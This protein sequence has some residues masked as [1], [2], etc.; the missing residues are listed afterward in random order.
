MTGEP[1]WIP[2][3]LDPTRPSPAR[4]YD[5]ALGGG[6]N[7]A[8]DRAVFEQVVKIQPNTRQMAWNNRAFMRRAVIFMVESGIRQF[9]DLGSGIPTVGN[10]H[11]IAGKADPACRVVYV[12]V[13]EMAIAHSRLLLDGVPNTGVVEADF[14]RPGDVLDHPETRR[15]LDFDAPL[16]LLAVASAHH[17]PAEVDV[18]DAFARYRAALVPGGALAISHLTDDFERVQAKQMVETVQAVAHNPVCLRTRSEIMDLFGDFELVEPGLVPPSKWRPDISH[19]SG[20]GEEDG[21]W[22]GV[23]IRNRRS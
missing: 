11:E 8:S 9:L 5:Y 12:D 22:A 6:H 18:Y 15:L 17:V 2:E 23:G 13:E 4:I 7:L 10:V 19:T 1:R 21:L 3:N 20:S 16:G 14:A